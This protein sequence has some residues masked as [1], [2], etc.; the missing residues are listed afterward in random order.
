MLCY[1]GEFL[2]ELSRL[3]IANFRGH[4]S[5]WFT[6]LSACRL[7]EFETSVIC[8]VFIHCLGSFLMQDM[9]PRIGFRGTKYEIYR[10]H[11]APGP[12]SQYMNHASNYL[13]HIL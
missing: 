12:V 8:H 9:S 2:V 7:A 11:V 10:E 13:H 6:L 5:A 1:K 4:R 3:S